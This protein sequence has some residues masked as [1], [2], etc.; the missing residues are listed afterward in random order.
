MM[1]ME[2]KQPAASAFVESLR[3]R[4]DHTARSYAPSPTPVPPASGQMHCYP[5][6]H[7]C[8]ISVWTGASGMFIDEAPATCSGATMAAAYCI[9]PHTQAC[10]Q[11]FDG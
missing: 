11:Y 9:D 7:R 4:S 6:P 3:P 5:Q 8:A 2:P 1:V 10:K